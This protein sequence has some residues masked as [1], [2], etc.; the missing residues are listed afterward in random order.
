VLSVCNL[1]IR[2]TYHQTDFPS[3]FSRKTGFWPTSG[4]Y[5]EEL[6]KCERILRAF[7]VEG[8]PTEETAADG[9]KKRKVFRKIAPAIIKNA[10]G[11]IIFTAMRS[12]FAP[13]GG[14]GAL[15]FALL[16]LLRASGSPLTASS[17]FGRWR[18]YHCH[19]NV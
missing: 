9:K 8:V 14:A 10:Q 5:A 6:N 19:E 1:S 11:L 17:L 4:D 15:D 7:T 16:A 13:F 3:F 18:R 2:A 12:G